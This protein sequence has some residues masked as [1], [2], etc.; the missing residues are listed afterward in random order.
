MQRGSEAF[1]YIIVTFAHV[2]GIWLL[3]ILEKIRTE[4]FQ[5]HFLVFFSF[6]EKILLLSARRS[7]CGNNFFLW[8]CDI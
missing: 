2:N 8:Y 1:T 5:I 7:I 4:C 6:S 3:F